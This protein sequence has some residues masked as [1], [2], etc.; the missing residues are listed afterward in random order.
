MTSGVV[1]HAGLTEAVALA[2]QY[3]EGNAPMM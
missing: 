3:P 1:D 2:P